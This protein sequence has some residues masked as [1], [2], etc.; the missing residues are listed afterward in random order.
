MPDFMLLL[1]TGRVQGQGSDVLRQRERAEQ[2]RGET[3]QSPLC[4]GL[5]VGLVFVSVR[6]TAC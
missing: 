1:L 4:R 2:A 6:S 5:P 3:H